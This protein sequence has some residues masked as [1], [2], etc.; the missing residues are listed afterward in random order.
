MSPV[1][2]PLAWAVNALSLPREDLDP[3]AFLPV[4]ILGKMVAKLQDFPCRRIILIAPWWPNIP[5]LWDL[6]AMLSQIPCAC[7]ICSYS[8]SIK[9]S[10][11]NLSNLNLHAWLLEPQQSRSRASLRQWQHELRLLRG[12]TRSVYEAKLTNFTKWCISNQVD[13]RATSIKS[14]A[15]FLLYLFQ[16]W[17]LQPNTING[18]RSAIA[19]KFGNSPI[20]VT[21]DENLLDSFGRDRPNGRRGIPS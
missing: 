13:F 9:T 17:K 2:D 19:D 12:S 16:V 10:H 8:L 18:Y 7:P 11:R 14:I 3:H 1:P 4:A 20:N 21:K 5:W 15:N 6:V